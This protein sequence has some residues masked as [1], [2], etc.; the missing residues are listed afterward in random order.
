M[1]PASKPFP[2]DVTVA[3][4][5]HNALAYLPASLASVA[6]AGCPPEQIVVVDVASTDGLV[7]WLSREWPGVAPVRLEVNDGPSPGRN[8]GIRHAQTKYVLLMDA[9]VRL[10]PD[11]LDI[12]HAAMRRDPTIGIGSPVVVHLDRPD[13]IQYA[14]TGLHFICEAVNPYLDRPLAERGDDARDIGAASTCALLLDR[15]LAI[16]VGL[17]DERYF[18][19]KED[20]DFT[21]RVKLAGFQIHE[22]PQA[23]VLHQSK[24]RGTWLFYYQIRNRWHFVLKNYEWQTIF[25]LLPAFVVH[26]TL[27]FV[28]LIAKGHGVTYFKALGGLIALLPT[29][30][31]DRAVTRSIRVRHDKAVLRDE[32]IVVR[33]DLAGGLVQQLLGVY[34]RALSAYWRLLARTVLP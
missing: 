10:L 12:L 8:A 21:H 15:E 2:A 32:P 6:A 14:C 23:R 20:G 33:A 5:A 18:I 31:R 24:P 4:V 17:F 30:R 1:P 3:I 27:Q 11:T 25:W 16:R 28:F 29:L 22:P 34:Q 9:D 7:D 26:E 19:G 13:V